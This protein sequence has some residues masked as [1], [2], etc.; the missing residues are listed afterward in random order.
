MSRSE[1]NYIL[2]IHFF[3]SYESFYFAIDPIFIYPIVLLNCITC[4]RFFTERWNEKSEGKASRI[5]FSAT[6]RI[7]SER[8]IRRNHGGG[9]SRNSRQ[10]FLHLNNCFLASPIHQLRMSVFIR[11]PKVVYCCELGRNTLLLEIRVK[12]RTFNDDRSI[13]RKGKTWWK[14]RRS[15][16]ISIIEI[17][18]TWL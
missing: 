6:N 4:I 5:L 1:S 3:K 10:V 16:E 14:K 2:Y 12:T 11:R 13:D 9:G 17:I 8:T 15:S 18:K 7:N